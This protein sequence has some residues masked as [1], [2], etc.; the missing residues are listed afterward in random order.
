MKPDSY[1]QHIRNPLAYLS[2]VASSTWLVACGTC[3]HAPPPPLKSHSHT[4][5]LGQTHGLKPELASVHLKH[6]LTP[7][8]RPTQHIR[9]LV[10]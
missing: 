5:S 3:L 4:L 10:H 9:T 7:V 1:C 2:D 8:Q 6:T